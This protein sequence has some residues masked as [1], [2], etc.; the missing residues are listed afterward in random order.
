MNAVMKR[1]AQTCRRELLNPT[2]VWNQRHLLRALREFE[3]FYNEKPAPPGHRER[4]TVALA[5]HADQRL[6][7]THPPTHPPT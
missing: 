1:W 6:R 7:R 2:L 4:P 5:A 3:S